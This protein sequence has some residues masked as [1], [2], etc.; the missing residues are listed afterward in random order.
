MAVTAKTFSYAA[1]VDRAG[2]VSA[3]GGPAAEIPADWKPEHLVL[4]GLVRCSLTSLRYHAQRSGIDVAG[5]SGEAS[6]RVTK[7]DHDERYAFV[8]VV[9]SFEVDLEPAPA[10]D[11]LR[12][13]LAKAERDCFVGASLTSPPRYRWTV[14]GGEVS[15]R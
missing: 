9:C 3:E 14:N 12:E 4:A 10:P 8:E 7:R 6:A 2:R 5:A 13:L 11:D 1:G 15:A